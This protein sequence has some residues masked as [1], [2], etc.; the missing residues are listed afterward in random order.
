MRET[1]P[2]GVGIIEGAAA[3]LVSECLVMGIIGG[4]LV[5]LRVQTVEKSC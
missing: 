5:S 2:A 4:R 1:K 3:M